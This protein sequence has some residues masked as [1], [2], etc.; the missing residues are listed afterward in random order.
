MIHLQSNATSIEIQSIL[1]SKYIQQ[2][3]P[4]YGKFSS[5]RETQS[6][7][8]NSEAKHKNKTRNY[9]NTKIRAPATVKCIENARIIF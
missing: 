4:T 7:K 5:D 3:H 9:S 1:N 8:S 6:K 2:H